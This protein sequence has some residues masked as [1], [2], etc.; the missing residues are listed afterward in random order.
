MDWRRDWRSIQI[1]DTNESFIISIVNECNGNFVFKLSDFKV[2]W[3]EQIDWKEILHRAKVSFVILCQAI[4]CDVLV[5]R[6]PMSV[7]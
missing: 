2:I 1:S 5:L 7:E 6:L 3:R 4:L